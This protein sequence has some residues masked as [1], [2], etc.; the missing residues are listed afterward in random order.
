MRCSVW[1]QNSGVLT[2]GMRL[3]VEHSALLASVYSYEGVIDAAEL[4]WFVVHPQA[5]LPA[6]FGAVT[7][8]GGGR[9]FH[10]GADLMDDFKGK[11][12]EAVRPDGI[13]LPYERALSTCPQAATA[14]CD[15]PGF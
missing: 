1:L 9:F 2:R 8:V 10:N 3:Q 5:D 6:S 12:A 15:H 13:P 11:L 7:A 4:A 14:S